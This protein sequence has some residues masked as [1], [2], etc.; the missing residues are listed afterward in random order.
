MGRAAHYMLLQGCAETGILV[1][2]RYKNEFDTFTEAQ[3]NRHTSKTAHQASVGIA[4]AQP[5]TFSKRLLASTKDV[6]AIAEIARALTAAQRSH[7]V[8][9][10]T[11]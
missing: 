10:R 8:V 5:K 1:K 7:N 3:Y 6:V 4:S 2:D 9:Q 11:T